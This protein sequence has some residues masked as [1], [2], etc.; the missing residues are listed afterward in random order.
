MKTIDEKTTIGELASVFYD[1]M[2]IKFARDAVKSAK[3]DNNLV[4]AI[5]FNIKE[6]AFDNIKI[7]LKLTVNGEEFIYEK[8]YNGTEKVFYI[9]GGILISES[10]IYE[11]WDKIKYALTEKLLIANSH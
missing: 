8:E 6:P 4:S 5:V 3:I 1:A 7:V 9:K 2:T 11:A 10:L